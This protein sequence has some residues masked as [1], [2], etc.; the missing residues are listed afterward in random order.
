MGKGT[1]TPVC[2]SDAG[3]LEARERKTKDNFHEQYQGSGFRFLN[4]IFLFIYGI[5]IADNFEGRNKN[6]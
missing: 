4:L 5:E 6:K 3:T 1:I 2:V